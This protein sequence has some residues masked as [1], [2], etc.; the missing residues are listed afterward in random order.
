MVSCESKMEEWSLPTMSMDTMG[1]SVYSRMPFKGPSAAA[2]M[3]ALISSAVTDF[4]SSTVR[5]TMEPSGVGTRVAKP[6][7]RPLSSGS[8]RDTARAAPV[9]VGIMD[10]AAARAR[11]RSLWGRSRIFWSLV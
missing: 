11:R 3:A 2:F 9:V 4:S 8:T 1:S 5:S 7:R 10:T 6:S